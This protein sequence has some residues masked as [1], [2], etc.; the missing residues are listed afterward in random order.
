MEKCNP[1]LIIEQNFIPILSAIIGTILLLLYSTSKLSD[2]VIIGF[3]YLLIAI[4]VNSIYLIYLLY[5]LYKNKQNKNTIYTR[6]AIT[7][8]N[9]PI[10]ILF[11]YIVFNV[12]EINF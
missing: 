2:V 7:L 10:S 5:L 12:L 11:V 3:I 8:S 6:I 1:N 4:A 9:I